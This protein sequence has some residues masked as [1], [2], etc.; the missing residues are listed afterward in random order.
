[1]K[2]WIVLNKEEI[3]ADI[4]SGEYEFAIVGVFNY[5][6]P[7][8]ILHIGIDKSFSNKEFREILYRRK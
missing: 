5:I 8:D 6:I 7:K 3:P 2:E 1:M 4:K